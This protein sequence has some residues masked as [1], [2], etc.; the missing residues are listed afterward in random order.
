M[1]R[2]RSKLDVPQYIKE[3]RSEKL[4]DDLRYLCMHTCIHLVP[5]SRPEGLSFVIHGYNG[6]NVRTTFRTTTDRRFIV[7]LRVEEVE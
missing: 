7:L 6:W 1:N 2:D 5:P 3:S 4:Y